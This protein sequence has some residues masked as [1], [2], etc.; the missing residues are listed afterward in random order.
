[1]SNYVTYSEYTT[2]G[3]NTLSADEATRYL[4]D[5]SVMIDALTFNRIVSLG[6][7]NLTDFQKW[8]VQ[9]CVCKQAD[10]INENSDAIGSVFDTYAINGVS[11][12]FGAGLNFVVENGIPTLSTITEE[13]KQSGLMWR[14]AV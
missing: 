8:I 5:A 13:L 6:F 3:Y 14:G 11:M 1:M 7:D 12:K 4:T 2:L 10:F 9:D